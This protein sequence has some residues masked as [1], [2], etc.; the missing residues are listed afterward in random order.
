MPYR[1]AGAG[2][3]LKATTRRFSSKPIAPRPKDLRRRLHTA[4][5]QIGAHGMPPKF[6]LS[7][8]NFTPMSKEPDIGSVVAYARR[9]EELEFESLWAWD[10]MFLGSRQPF[11]FLESL[12][13]LTVLAVETEKVELGTG[14]LVLPLRNA[15]VL[16]K[17]AA[18]VDI[19]SQ[20]RL[21]LGMAVG[22]YEREFD[23]C[24]VPFGSGGGSLRRTSTC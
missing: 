1:G 21:T 19:I 12:S 18:T 15:A 7:V 11:P 16:A 9:A 4:V 13:T 10:H 22:W 14:V 5:G 3:S 17:T 2:K 20:G 6:G 8:E 24:G 23:A